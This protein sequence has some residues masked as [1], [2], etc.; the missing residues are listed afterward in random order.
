MHFSY[1]SHQVVFYLGLHELKF[2]QKKIHHQ[3]ISCNDREKVKRKYDRQ[4]SEPEG[5]SSDVGS[6]EGLSPSPTVMGLTIIMKEAKN[7]LKNGSRFVI[8]FSIISLQAAIH[9]DRLDAW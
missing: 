2:R 4:Q 6:Q 9:N 5:E 1:A 7:A 3:S 8:D